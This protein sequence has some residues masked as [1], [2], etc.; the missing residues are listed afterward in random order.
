M[1][2][3]QLRLPMA[4]DH[5]SISCCADRQSPQPFEDPAAANWI[6][7]QL[8]TAVSPVYRIATSLDRKD[9]LGSIKARWGVGRMNYTV[10]PGLYVIGE[11]DNSSPV[12][13][14]ANYKLSFDYMR[15]ELTGLNLWILV[16]DT[17][18][19]NVWCAAGKGSFGT[20]EVIRMVGVSSLS[21]LVS[22]RTLILPQLAAP[23]V[24][25]HEVK[26]RCGFKIVYG[27]VRAAD[28]PAFLTSGNKA[29]PEMRHPGFTLG[30]RLIL[31][32]VELIALSKPII[33]LTAFLFLLNLAAVLLKGSPV[34][35]LPLLG[36]TFS[37]LAPFFVAMLVGAVL[38]PA[39]LPYIPGRALAWKGWVLGIIWAFV[40]TFIAT[41]Q[42]GWLTI[43]AYFLTIPALTAFLGMNFTGSTTYTSLSG[44][45]K[46][47]G[48]AL[49]LIIASASLGLIALITTFFI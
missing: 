5:Q 35:V 23:G 38:V 20:A 45:V 44:V 3:E 40:Y 48:I 9:L 12:L 4:G 15:R 21:E 7:G 25:A 37:D 16:L 32:P 46:E 10:P 1:S 11:P 36:Q 14:S 13:V 29:E 26:R 2:N 33:G 18:G 31:T 24:A 17:R 8:E 22:H 43:A 34:S 47:M 30:D 6:T 39:L 27:P 49:P 42:P 28:I 19:I 41:T